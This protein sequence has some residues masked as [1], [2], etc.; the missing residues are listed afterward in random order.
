MKKNAWEGKNEVQDMITKKK[1]AF[2]KPNVVLIASFIRRLR[3]MLLYA[4]R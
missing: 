4:K 3:L 1:L 2:V